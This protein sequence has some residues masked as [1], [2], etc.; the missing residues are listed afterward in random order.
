MKIFLT[1]A[2]LLTFAMPS[3]ALAD[4]IVLD[5]SDVGTSFTV[6]FGGYDGSGTIAGLTG[7]AIFTLTSMTANS[8]TFGYTVNNTSTSPITT[9]R[10]SGFGFNTDPNISGASSTG[11]YNIVGT[12]S[13][14]PNVGTVD[15]CFKDG[16]GTN[17]CAGGG[18]GGVAL[19]G[20]GSGTL[21][22]SFASA[23]T[24]LNISDFFVRYQSITGTNAN[25]PSSAVGSGTISTTSG[26][27]TSGGST[28]GVPVPEPGMI[29][30]FM[31]GAA[32]LWFRRRRIA[33]V[34]AKLAFA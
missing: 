20:T 26:G 9:S 34:Q 11:A 29:G 7:S 6:G 33:P 32:G 10:I 18:A 25:T 17:S 28:G 31:L 8:Y 22:L 4:A 24:S 15:V 13:N 21:T 16:G 1:A 3:V 23:L 27:S 12:A 19:G 30:L 2:A 14:V 5:S